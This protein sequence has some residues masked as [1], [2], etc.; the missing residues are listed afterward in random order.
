MV[1]S[2]Y[3]GFLIV[4]TGLPSPHIRLRKFFAFGSCRKTFASADETI[5]SRSR[6]E[7]TPG[8]DV[9]DMNE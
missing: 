3:S 1:V 4:R 9:V 2:Q 6:P 7:G 8:L 5:P